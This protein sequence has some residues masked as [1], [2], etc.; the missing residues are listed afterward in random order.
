MALKPDT[1]TLRNLLNE[2]FDRV[3]LPRN[4]VCIIGG[5]SGLYVRGVTNDLRDIDLLVPALKA[6]KSV[7]LPREGGKT[8]IIDGY[9]SLDHLLPG[10]TRRILDTKENV[11]GFS[12]N[13]LEA[14]LEVKKVL[15]RSKDAQI[16]ATLERL[17]M[18]KSKG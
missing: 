8:F 16:I 17:I 1:E 3:D 4:T 11:N 6:D 12:V 15:N 2:F 9:A 14:T 7:V 10:I 5:G 18:L 13:S